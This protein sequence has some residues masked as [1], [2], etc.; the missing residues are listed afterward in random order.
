M[1]SVQHRKVRI[2]HVL[3]ACSVLLGA[4]GIA[5][6]PVEA[7]GGGCERGT[8]SGGEYIICTP[9]G[10]AWNG[11][12]LIYAHGYVAPGNPVEIPED[13]LALGG[14]TSITE[15]LTSLGFAFAATS[16]PTNGLAVTEGVAAVR[17]L[18]DLF[19]TMEGAPDHVYLAGASEGG[20]V[21]ALATEQYPDLFAGGL[22]TCGPVGDFQRQINYWADVRVLFDTFFP[23]VL[24]AFEPVEG[25]PQAPLIPDEVIDSWYWCGDEDRNANYPCVDNREDAYQTKVRQALEDDPDKTR[26]L[27]RVARVPVSLREPSRAIDALVELLWYNVFAT[28]DGIAKLGGQPYDNAL[29]WYWGSNNDWRLNRDVTRFHANPGAAQ[30]I[31]D[32]YQTSGDLSVPIVTLHTLQD[33]VVPYWHEPIY[34]WKVWKNDD[35]GLHTN[36]PSLRYGHCNFGIGE[37]LFSLAWLIYQVEGQGLQNVG[38]VLAPEAYAEYAEMAESYGLDPGSDD[39]WMPPSL[40]R[41]MEPVV[42]T[43]DQLPLLQGTPTNELFV[44]A[45]GD[46]GYEQIP[47]QVDEV[48]TDTYTAING[49]PLDDDDEVVFMA[50][51]LGGRPLGDEEITATLP[52]SATWYRVEVTDP[53]IPMAKGWAYVVRSNDLT[54]TFT[55]TYASFDPGTNRITADQYSAGFLA[56]HPGF[57]HLSLHQGED[58]LDRTKMRLQ[59]A[60]VTLTENQL[61]VGVPVPIKDGPVRVIV[62]N[63]GTIGYGSLLQTWLREGNRG[64]TSA[65]LSTDFNQT[66]SGATFYNATVPTGVTVDGSP[67]PAVQEEPLSPWWQ[68]SHTSGTLVQVADTAGVGGTQAN[69]YLDDETEDADDTGDQRSYGDTG[70]MVDGPSSTIEYRTSLYVL[71]G[72]LSNVGEMYAAQ[73]ANPLRVTALAPST[74]TQSIYLP[75]LLRQ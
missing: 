19:T 14:G 32:H 9:D 28:N 66:A 65:R 59:V 54:E 31:E 52:I 41:D 15:T 35:Q 64:A 3:V 67:D 50:S 73:A 46:Q 40:E 36:I 34:R 53:L 4:L 22:A 10:D 69:Y 5:A 61:P 47:F 58:I 20:I 12:L 25:D 16:Y 71:P 60:G 38:D 68:V 56:G 75:M 48:A 39:A 62:Q 13:Q 1:R 23:G 17:D 49:S 24:P 72:G 45:Y 8:Y 74:L 27:V 21:T 7:T 30:R 51:D 11:D 26:Q 29:R 42:V 6:G 2:V 63:R 57:D 44:Y 43:G 37:A 55:Q 70:L 33:P 18:V